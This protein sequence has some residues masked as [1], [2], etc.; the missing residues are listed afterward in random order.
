MTKEEWR[1]YNKIAQR[2]YRKKQRADDLLARGHCPVCTM[3]LDAEFEKYHKMFKC[4]YYLQTH[5]HEKIAKE[6][7][8]SIVW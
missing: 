1:E 5:I 8:S 7:E 4:P 6:D 3:L 2:R